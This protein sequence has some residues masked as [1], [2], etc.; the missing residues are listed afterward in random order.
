MEVVG[1]YPW[2][3]N[4]DP[5]DEVS[6]PDLVAGKIHLNP[7]QD[8]DG[9]R[10]TTEILSVFVKLRVIRE[11]RLPS[12]TKVR[13]VP[14]TLR[15]PVPLTKN[16]KFRDSQSPVILF[17]FMTFMTGSLVVRRPTS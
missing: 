9:K 12:S 5:Y 15:V 4:L 14:E 3:L 7:D 16:L 8:R 1:T 10:P 17:V 11:K 13:D 6:G 2:V